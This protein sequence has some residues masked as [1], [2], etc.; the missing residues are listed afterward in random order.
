LVER[1]CGEPAQS[2]SYLSYLRG[3]F[4]QLYGLN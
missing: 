2:R 4:G 3:K 1:V